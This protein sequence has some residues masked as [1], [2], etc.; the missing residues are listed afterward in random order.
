MQIQRVAGETGVGLVGQCFED[1]CV[2]DQFRPRATYR[3]CPQGCGYRAEI[4]G[5]AALE[6][7]FRVQHGRDSARVALHL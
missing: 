3:V 2:A 1:K 7:Y 4:S 6:H 5:I